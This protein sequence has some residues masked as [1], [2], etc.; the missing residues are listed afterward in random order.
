MLVGSVGEAI[1]TVSGSTRGIEQAEDTSEVLEG[2]H[3][4]K[5]GVAYHEDTTCSS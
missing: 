2:S 5:R 4:T 1:L 3:S